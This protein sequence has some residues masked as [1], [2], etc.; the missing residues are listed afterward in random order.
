M[1]NLIIFCRLCNALLPILPGGTVPDS[2]F[3]LKATEKNG[4]DKEEKMDTQE[5]VDK[6]PIATIEEE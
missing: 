3:E 2:A 6:A 1:T 4:G 5:R